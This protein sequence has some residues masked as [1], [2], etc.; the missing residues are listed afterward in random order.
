MGYVTEEMLDLVGVPS[1]VVTADAPLTEDALR[2]FVQAAMLED[3]IHWDDSAARARGFGGIVAMPLFPMH[4]FPR[5]SG[6]PDPLDRLQEDPD[7]DGADRATGA[8]ATLP[9]LDLPLRRMLNGGSESE[10]FQLARIGDVISAQSRYLSITERE[11]RSGPM[12]V[13]VMETR[14]TNQDGA[15]LMRSR[16]TM[17]LR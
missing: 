4:A 1:R 17:V 11:G 14:Y 9:P 15:V 3:P 8:T 6:T 2:R 16:Q 12:V 10:I 5:R 7:W 13:T